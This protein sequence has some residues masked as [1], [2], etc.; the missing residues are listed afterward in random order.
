MMA[1]SV[2]SVGGRPASSSV[3]QAICSSSRPA[4][5]RLLARRSFDATSGAVGRPDLLDPIGID[6]RTFEHRA[7]DR[8]V[9]ERTDV[10]EVEL[11]EDAGSLGQGESGCD[12][13]ADELVAQRS[14]A[15]REVARLV[16]RFV[17][18]LVVD[19]DPAVLRVELVDLLAGEVAFVAPLIDHGQVGGQHVEVGLGERVAEL[20][21]DVG[22]RPHGV[23]NLVGR[24]VG[25]ILERRDQLGQER[26]DLDRI[27]VVDIVTFVG[28]RLDIEGDRAPVGILVDRRRRCRRRRRRGRL[29]RRGGRRRLGTLVGAAAAASSD[30]ELVDD[31]RRR[32]SRQRA[33]RRQP[34]GRS[35]GG[36]IAF[37]T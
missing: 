2:S 32:C 5:A 1:C 3:T 7:E 36:P 14:F 8:G 21:R 10:G 6:A 26:L 9:I 11:V 17:A 4:A 13:L 35:Y 16:P 33:R 22:G 34:G 27:G 12:E 23:G 29:G 37:E 18:G 28:Q 31:R 30:D 15:E 19:H 25:G 24:R 20:G